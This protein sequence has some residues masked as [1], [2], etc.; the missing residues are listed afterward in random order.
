MLTRVYF[1]PSTILVTRADD[2]T[3]VV[4]SSHLYSLHWGLVIP[5]W[6]LTMRTIVNDGDKPETD[7]EVEGHVEAE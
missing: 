2:G 7:D 5:T 1:I 4:S 6:A 3:A